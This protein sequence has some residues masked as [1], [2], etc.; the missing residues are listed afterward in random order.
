[1]VVC[2]NLRI[3]SIR[4]FL[5]E[6]YND[7]HGANSTRLCLLVPEEP[8]LEMKELLLMYKDITYLKGDA[9]LVTDL[10]RANVTGADACFVLSDRLCSSPEEEDPITMLRTLNILKTCRGGHDLNK[11]RDISEAD[12][13]QRPIILVQI[14]SSTYKEY[15][16]SAGVQEEHIVCITEIKYSLLG[17]TFS[18]PLS[19]YI[20]VYHPGTGIYIRYICHIGIRHIYIYATSSYLTVPYTTPFF[21]FKRT[22][23]CFSGH[24]HP[25]CNPSFVIWGSR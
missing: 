3:S 6:F 15:L 25:L 21:S 12:G 8:T 18:L 19:L 20:Y 10:N 24:C 7:D 13:L 14:V 17:S 22:K 11:R 23:L 5:A 16:I 1:M 2:C 4:E 9:L